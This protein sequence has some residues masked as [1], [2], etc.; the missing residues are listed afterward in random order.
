MVRLFAVLAFLVTQLSQ[1]YFIGFLQNLTPS[2]IDDGVLRAWPVAV[3]VNLGLLALFGLVHSVMARPGFKRWWLQMIPE[4]LE[5]VVYGLVSAM[6]LM[7]L[8]GL[9]SP[10]P[11]AVWSVELT[12]LRLALYAVFGIGVFLIMWSIWCVDL[13]HFTGLK[14]AFGVRGEPPFA[15]RGPYRWVRHPIQTGLMM[16]LWATPEMTAGHLMMA[17]VLSAYSIL[18]TLMLE[19][20]DLDRLV[21]S[22]YERY[23]AQV[24]AFIPRLRRA[25]APVVQRSAQ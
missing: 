15:M 23:R 8:V 7:L 22:A 10:V 12:E 2:G 9:W 4:K 1:A 11:Q 19:E 6:L 16:A 3:A 5:R 20:R 25:P 24:P 17:V 13:L 18:A 14:Q 21:G